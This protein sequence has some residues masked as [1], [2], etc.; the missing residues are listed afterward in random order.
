MGAPKERRKGQKKI[1]EKSPFLI[2]LKKYLAIYLRKEVHSLCT[3][4][5]KIL[6]NEIKY[7]N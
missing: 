4:N 2:P 1:L 5:Y 3:K 7:L 6:L